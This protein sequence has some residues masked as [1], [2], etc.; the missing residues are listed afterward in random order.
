MAPILLLMAGFFLPLYPLSA[1]PNAL[2]QGQVK[3]GALPNGD[4]RRGPAFKATLILVF[5]LIG[6]GLL[7]LAMDQPSAGDGWP[8]LFAVWGGLTSVLYAFRLLSAKDGE[9][10]ISHLYSS[11]LALIWIGVGSGV[12][13]LLPAI[14]LSISLLP[15]V[16]LL[17]HLTRRFGIARSGLYPGLCCRLPW[18]AHLFVLAVL[19]AIAVP[20]SPSFFALAA[21]AFGG[22]AADAVVVLLPIC[23]SWLLWTWAGVNLLSGIVWGVPREDLTYRDLEPRQAL[24]LGGGMIALGLFGILLVEVAL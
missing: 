2:L 4:W 1:L 8:T 24:G 23:L 10:W 6:I 14:G 11:A 5:P 22:V 16:F 18:L 3:D 21:L 17:D 20:F 9:I 13:S 12:S 15:L 7:A 19:A